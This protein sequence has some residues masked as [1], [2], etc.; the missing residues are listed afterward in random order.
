MKPR[1]S[2]F[3]TIIPSCN[4]VTTCNIVTSLLQIIFI[5]CGGQAMLPSSN[6]AHAL[7]LPDLGLVQLLLWQLWPI[8]LQE[9]TVPHLYPPCSA[10]QTAWELCWTQPSSNTHLP[11]GTN[12]SHLPQSLSKHC[13]DLCDLSRAAP[14]QNSNTW[15]CRWGKTGS[16][17]HYLIQQPGSGSSFA[18]PRSHSKKCDIHRQTEMRDRGQKKKGKALLKRSAGQN[19]LGTQE[20]FAQSAT[21]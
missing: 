2:V 21:K 8:L 10:P 13:I 9:E 20:R 17:Y 7:L 12:T 11:I 6:T 1:D 15:L 5:L 3:N 4:G 19:S 18:C 16:F 14:V